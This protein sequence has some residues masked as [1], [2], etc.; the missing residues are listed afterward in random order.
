MR[1]T[2]WK[3]LFTV[4]T[5]WGCEART[6][7]A[8]SSLESQALAII[9]KR[10]LSCHGAELKTS[11]LDLSTLQS[12]LRGGSAGPALK[13]GQPAETLLLRRI[14]QQ[15][16][17]PGNP[18]PQEERTLLSQW[19]LEGAPWSGQ[20][21]KVAGPPRRAGLDWWALQPL[22]ALPFA[23]LMGLPL[24]WSHS[25]VDRFIYAKLREKGLQPSPPADRTTFIRRA[26]FDL[27]GLPPTPEE[28]DHFVQDTS[29]DAYEKLIDRLL[30]SPHYGERWGRHWLDVI[31]FGES[32]GYEQNHLRERAWPFR[33]YIIRSLNQD[34][35]F[36][37]MVLEQLAGDR[38]APDDPDVTVATG[39]LVAGVHDTVKIENIEG[40]LQ[41]RANDLDDMVLTTSAAFLGLTVN[42]AR[43][44]DHKFD[45]IP[46]VDYYRLQA[47][48]AGVQHAERELTTRKEQTLREAQEKP[49]REDLEQAN[50][51]LASLKQSGWPLAESGRPDISK[52]Y[53]QS[54][55]AK[56]NEEKFSPVAARFVRMTI[57]A[58]YKNQEPALDE[59]EVWTAGK[60]PVNVALASR[61]AKASARS[62]RTD[63]KGAAFYK[64]D[65]LN[66]GKFDEIWISDERDTGQ[67]TLDFPKTETISRITW[68]RDRPG[69]NQGR[70]LSRVPVTY[71]FETSLD[72]AQWRRV[73][74]S[75]DRLPFTE[76]EREDFFLLSVL[77]PKEKNEWLALKQRKA[78]TEKKLA[79]L[80]K[81]PTAYIGR[82]TQP[83]EPVALH[84]RGNPMD[85]GDIVAPGGLSALQ[86]MLPVYEL[87]INA[88]EDER[89]LALAR[90]IVDD[91]NGLTARVLANRLWHYHFGKGLVGTP[92][93]FGYNGEK[94]T[95]PELLEWL[96]R[97]LLHHGWRLKPMHK[98]LMLSG[99]YRQS[100]Q[101][102]PEAAAIDSE[103]RTLWR[104][105]TRR[106]EAEAVRDS[107]LAVSGKLNRTL[108]GPGFRLYDYTVDNVA[109]YAFRPNFGPETYRRGVYHQSAR[110]VKDDLMGPF[111]CP[112][113]A[114]PEPKRVSTTTALQALSLLN[115]AFIID[116]ASFF[117]ERLRREAG[118]LDV[119]A[120][121][122]L[123]FRLAFGR[124]P[125]DEEVSSAVEL[126]RRH[127]LEAFCRALLNA[128][129]FLYVM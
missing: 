26:T 69:A 84:K 109:T 4:L 61:G 113:S 119:K 110:S 16:M 120:Q 73:A 93:D 11:G 45:P 71:V 81:P 43:C 123:A 129:E 49:L 76:E 60:S 107:I 36:S 38:L 122:T 117:A 25:T 33:D 57:L 54:V 30:A 72:G 22:H 23:D 8:K 106:L 66:D 47:A 86:K 115:N 64:L 90:W 1:Q 104:F 56:G 46:Q 58:T 78:E 17:P 82:F 101:W 65:F 15:Q 27:L 85:R 52:R 35:P 89:R 99:V 10:C 112:D 77:V 5:V 44:H 100:G 14:I 28:I 88:P 20:I 18:L 53:R 39:F 128:N 74:S 68:S 96:A 41:K 91:R 32:H 21:G 42:C 34:K 94:P 108:G 37:K 63:G 116:Q 7:I 121:V 103:A 12:A 127:D 40:E 62:T 70:F 87:D 67:V 9:E 98:E 24:E 6:A 97:R 124:T 111:D 31:R 50:K 59:L 51:R 126:I 102:N 55:D 75:D 80:P 79:A 105:P 114:L 13:P 2:R 118:E 19:I 83:S 48:F 95:H 92:S 29:P 3:V 125:K